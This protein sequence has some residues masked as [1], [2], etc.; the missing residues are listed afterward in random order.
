MNRK[1]KIVEQLKKPSEKA[2]YG[3]AGYRSNTDDLV[4]IIC[5]SSFI[6]YLRSASF[7]GKRIGIMITASHNPIDYNGVK[8]IDHNG[9]MLDKSWEKCSDDLVNCED[10]DFHN[11]LNKI[12]RKN[13]NLCDINDGITGHVVI[14]RDTRV[15][16]G[17]ISDKIKEVLAQV[18]CIIEDYGEVSTPQ[19]HFLIRKSNESN[20]LVDKSAYLN[21]LLDNL[22]QLKNLTQIDTP[23]L[24]DTANGIVEQN[25]LDDFNIQIINDES[26][27]LN[28]KCGADFVN[29]QKKL[30]I[31]KYDFKSSKNHQLFASFDGD[32]DRLILFTLKNG[33]E[34]LDGDAQAIILSKY[35]TKLLEKTE[36]KLKMGV[37]LSFYSNGGCLSSLKKVE[38]EMV[39]TG[40]KNFV[41]AAKKYDIGIY[42]EPNG[43][44][45]VIF[46]NL[47]IKA[48]SSGNTFEHRILQILSNLFD[49]NIG[50]ALANLLVL[51]SIIDDTTDLKNYNENGSRLLAVRIKNKN[52][53]T[54]NEQNKVITPGNLQEKINEEVEKSQGRGF[55]RPSGTEDLVRV[56]AECANQKDADILALKIAQHVYDICD[57]IGKHPEIDY[58]KK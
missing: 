40:V 9:N 4:N 21:H 43:H 29:T 47:A 5:R 46:S 32:A 33:F 50:D 23:I 41:K 52:V 27:I 38:T 3:T 24:A 17:F 55:V 22:S 14:G 37:I 36:I 2:Y 34:M 6:A 28:E 10:K 31:L 13:S 19:M 12:L 51:K 58:S 15:S 20:S 30:P 56:Y 54:T 39:Q 7:A 48:F 26:G 45:S 8:F 11:N 35:F 18:D 25:I 42:F 1:I 57:G 53:I 16:G 44:G 49:P